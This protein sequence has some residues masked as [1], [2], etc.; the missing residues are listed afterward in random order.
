MTIVTIIM[1]SKKN[2]SAPSHRVLYAITELLKV[3]RSPIHALGLQHVEIM[4]H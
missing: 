4:N 2:Y 3:P 1:M